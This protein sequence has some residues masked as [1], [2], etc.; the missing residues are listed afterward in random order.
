M[1]LG[2]LNSPAR[3]G[4]S[5]ETNG[6]WQQQQAN[7]YYTGVGGVVIG[8]GVTKTSS[9]YN[10]FVSKGILTEKVKV[11]VNNTSAWS[12]KVFE[13]GYQL[14]SLG[15]V[16]SY[17][18]TEGH[19]PGIPSAAEVVREGVDVGQ[20]QAKLL[21]KVEEL[22][23]YIIQLESKVKVLERRVSQFNQRSS[24]ATKR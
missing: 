19:L 10:L 9:D 1:I 5:S 21:E 3:L 2:S 7:T 15:E 12:D 6:L 4:A 14:R 13:E 17:I 8:E 11:A 20:M 22:T 16:S 24:S 23:L 18:K